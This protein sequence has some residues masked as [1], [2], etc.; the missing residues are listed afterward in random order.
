MISAHERSDLIHIMKMN[1]LALTDSDS[2]QLEFAGEVKGKRYEIRILAVED[3][4]QLIVRSGGEVLCSEILR[5]ID[6]LKIFLDE[7]LYKYLKS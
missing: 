1:R 2:A 7:Q 6:D 4:P 3:T 5:S